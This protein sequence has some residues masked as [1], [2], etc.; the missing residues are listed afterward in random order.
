[1]SEFENKRCCFC[2]QKPVVAEILGRLVC[3]VHASRMGEK[4]EVKQVKKGKPLN[5]GDL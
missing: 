3:K 4:I 2:L 1:M 5:E